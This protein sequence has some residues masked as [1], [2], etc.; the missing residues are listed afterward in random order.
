MIRPGEVIRVVLVDDEPPAR[1]KLRH[2]LS[3]ETDFAVVGEAGSAAE[4]VEV[5]NHERPD[6]VFLDIQLPDATGFDVLAALEERAG[7]HVSFV[8]A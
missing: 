3:P 8:T 4:A 7:L 5:L 6:V 2:L 1:R